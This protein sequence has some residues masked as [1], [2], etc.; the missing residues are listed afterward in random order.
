MLFG[1]TGYTG[2]LVA[3][4]LVDRGADPVLAG[5]GGARLARLADK[6]GGLEVRTADVERPAGV[7]A[8]VDAGD[9]LVTTVGPFIR[10]GQPAV[11][12][13]LTKHATY[14]DSTG[15]SAFLRDLADRVG[16]QAAANGTALL[17]AFGYDYVPGNLAG[18][19][20]LRRAGGSATRLDVGYFA[21]GKGGISGGTAASSVGALLLPSF[22]FSR[23]RLTD[24]RQGART[25]SFEVAGRALVA[26]AVGGTEHLFLPA[27]SPG[28]RDVGV[29]LGWLGALG[30][31]APGA[32]VVARGLAAVPGVT[33][34]LTSAMARF[35]GST[36]GPDATARASSGSLVVAEALGPAGQVLARVELT[37]PDPYTLTARL[38]AWGATTAVD[39]G[40][41][42]SG[43]LGPVE[44]FGLDELE[45]ACA[46]TGLVE[47][48]TAS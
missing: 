29:Y 21:T 17:P 19:L 15:E 18:A 37:G 47:S 33:P 36:G 22:R 3:A 23:G 41:R 7:D 20:A 10:W 39:G 42:G 4:E 32:A 24:D 2:R 26:T 46:A 48:A 38:L 31:L 45:K 11:K 12:A 16:Q 1:A 8:L 5:R 25:R 40:V 9:V 14:L 13:A 43:V 28:L 27:F 34:A 6:L 35:R 44:A 30:R